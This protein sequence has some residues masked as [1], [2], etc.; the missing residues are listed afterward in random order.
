MSF[1]APIALDNVLNSPLLPSFNFT[2][3]MDLPG[4]RRGEQHYG[5]MMQ[6][7]SSVSFEGNVEVAG[8]LPPAQ[9]GGS[10]LGFMS[11]PS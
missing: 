10:S 7:A 3:L 1:I 9:R 8:E 11:V 4:K 5:I 6:R 2:T